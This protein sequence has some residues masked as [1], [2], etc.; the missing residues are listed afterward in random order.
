MASAKISEKYYEE[1]D[2]SRAMTK[3]EKKKILGIKNK[4][5]TINISSETYDEANV[6]DKFMNMGYQNVLKV[7]MTLGL[8]QLHSTIYERKNLQKLME[9]SV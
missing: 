3:S 5:I 6:L 4:R 2:F 8:S 9:K 7:A 1:T